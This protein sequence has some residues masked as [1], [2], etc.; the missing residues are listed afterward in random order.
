MTAS[1]GSELTKER[2][3]SLIR[4]NPP[5]IIAAMLSEF[6]NTG[7]PYWAWKVVSICVKNNIPFP[8]W[9]IGYLD[10]CADRMLSDE[11]KEGGRDLRKVLPWVFGFPNGIGATLRR[12]GPGNLLDPIPEDQADKTIFAI[13][14]A[15]RLEEGELPS[16]AMLNA[17][18]DAFKGK[19]ANVD[20]KTLRRW[21]LNEFHLDAW[22]KTAEAWKEVA[23]EHFT[24][25]YVTFRDWAKSRET[26][27]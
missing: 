15:T 18:N 27:P 22:P 23:R 11:A 12:R 24:S 2:F 21:L 13:R 9:V 17:C 10:Q 7:N 5:F 4:K 16:E 26:P 6:A 1:A 14:F 19:N 8:D 25:I 3:F 20:E